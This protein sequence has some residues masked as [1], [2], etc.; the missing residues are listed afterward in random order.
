MKKEKGLSTVDITTIVLYLLGGGTRKIHHE[1]VALACWR[2]FPTKF[3]WSQYPQYPDIKPSLFALEAGRK[4]DYGNIIEGNTRK[5]WMLTVRGVEW[6]KTN[7]K[8]VDEVKKIFEEQNSSNKGISITGRTLG[9]IRKPEEEIANLKN[10]AAFEKFMNGEKISIDVYDFYRFMRINQ[11]VPK[12][13]YKQRLEEAKM[14][15]ESD[16][17]LNELVKYLDDRFGNNYQNPNK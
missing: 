14:L 9:V 17:S 4:S 13:K 6:I 15:A 2:I 5:G 12:Q 16:S 1:D 7:I 11:Y 10:T 3:S 8:K